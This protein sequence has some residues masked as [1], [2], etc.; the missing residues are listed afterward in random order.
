MGTE[1]THPLEVAEACRRKAHAH[2]AAVDEH[3]HAL[4]WVACARAR[5][6][7]HLQLALSGHAEDLDNEL[8]R[9]GQRKGRQAP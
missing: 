7:L 8:C 6:T 5:Q 9:A 4:A 3:V 2:V 1:A